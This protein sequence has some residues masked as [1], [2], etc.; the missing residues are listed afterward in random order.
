MAINK[1]RAQFSRGTWFTWSSWDSLA[2]ADRPMCTARG[3]LP[4]CQYSGT[5]FKESAG[6]VMMH[7]LEAHWWT[8]FKT[9]TV[10]RTN[11]GLAD[12][13]QCWCNLFSL[14]LSWL[15]ARK[16]LWK[17]A[18]QTL[19]IRNTFRSLVDSRHDD[20]CFKYRYTVMPSFKLVSLYKHKS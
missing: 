20:L 19:N 4:S 16:P 11:L 2:I 12:F 6:S 10:P 7:A 9:C 3:V 14:Q 17:Q 13:A 5:L 8:L 15:Q 1:T 18:E